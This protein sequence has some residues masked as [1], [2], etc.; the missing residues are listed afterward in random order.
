MRYLLILLLFPITSFSGVALVAGN[1]DCGTWL[2]ARASNQ[3]E[4]LQGYVHGFAN[5]W[6]L[7]SGES[8]WF[9]KHQINKNQLF[10]ALD[11]YCKEKPL[12]TLEAGIIQLHEEQ[13]P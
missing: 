1:N 5:G 9:G 4:I 7:K 8:I 2:N 3:A 13:N 11:F 10:Y 6:S 12:S